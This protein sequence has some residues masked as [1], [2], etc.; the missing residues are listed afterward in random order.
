M[1]YFYPHRSVY[2]LVTPRRRSFSLQLTK[3]NRDL[4]VN[5]GERMRELGALSHKWDVF[6]KPLPSRL[7]DLWKE[8]VQ[9]LK[10]PEGMYDSKKTVSSDTAELVHI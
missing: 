9:S 4:H 10:E 6:T 7:R 2:H 1:K 8:R 3:M 5:N